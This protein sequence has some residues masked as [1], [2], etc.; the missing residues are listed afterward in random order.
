MHVQEVAMEHASQLLISLAILSLAANAILNSRGPTAS[1]PSVCLQ[2]SCLT[3]QQNAREEEFV[4]V[5]WYAI[6]AVTTADRHKQAVAILS[7]S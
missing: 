2:A 7:P 3:Q 4:K 1:S 6:A 5:D